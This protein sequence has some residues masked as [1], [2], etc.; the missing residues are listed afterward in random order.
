[1]FSVMTNVFNA[2]VSPTSGINIGA[3]SNKNDLMDPPE[4]IALFGSPKKMKKDNMI[5]RELSRL[6][7]SLELST[8]N[9]YEEVRN[10]VKTFVRHL[11]EIMEYIKEHNIT[12]IEVYNSLF[13][14][15]NM[16]KFNTLL[17]LSFPMR[18]KIA[19]LIVWEYIFEHCC[20]ENM[21]NKLLSIYYTAM[22]L[23]NLVEEDH[24]YGGN[25]ITKFDSYCLLDIESITIGFNTEFQ[26]KKRE[27]VLLNHYRNY[28]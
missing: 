22:K 16:G 11:P 1:M 20:N 17:K 15:N 14:T 13:P 18:R 3:D 27:N 23:V 2:I 12:I 28:T 19:M 4:S 8:I 10:F 6:A 5:L 24:Q 25:K 26:Q 9:S 21:H 7:N